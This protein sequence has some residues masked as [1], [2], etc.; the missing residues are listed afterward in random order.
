MGVCRIRKVNFR[1]RP[2]AVSGYDVIIIV[3][4]EGGGV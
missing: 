4:V 2:F 3:K 1:P